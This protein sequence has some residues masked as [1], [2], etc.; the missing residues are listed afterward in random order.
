MLVHRRAIAALCVALAAWITLGIVHPV[1]A[2]TIRIWTA[3][4]D[5]GGGELLT[6]ADLHP[7]AYPRDLVP[8]GAVRDRDDLVGRLLAAPLPRGQPLTEAVVLG[9]GRLAG[10]PG[11]SALGLR[12][13]DDDVAALLR[14]GEEVDLVATDPQGAHPAELLVHGAVVLAVPRQ[15]PGADTASGTGRLVVFGVPREEAEHVAD[16]ASARYL[17]V[18]WN[19]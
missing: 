1:P 11:R 10:Y 7:A 19:R 6:S 2:P 4:H 15:A 18:I 17:A 12:V 13:P 8:S 5:L 9:S 16:V 3:A 14:P